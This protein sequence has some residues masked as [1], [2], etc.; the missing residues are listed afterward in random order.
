MELKILVQTGFSLGERIMFLDGNTL[1]CQYCGGKVWWRGELTDFSL[2]GFDHINHKISCVKCGRAS[3]YD[4]K[5]IERH[6]V[7]FVGLWVES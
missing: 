3:Y 4:E 1:L 5:D 6:E 7:N 2:L